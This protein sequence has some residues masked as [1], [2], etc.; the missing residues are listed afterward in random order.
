MSKLDPT[1]YEP[2]TLAIVAFA[3]GVTVTMAIVFLLI[4]WAA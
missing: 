1:R 3:I 2:S 4:Y